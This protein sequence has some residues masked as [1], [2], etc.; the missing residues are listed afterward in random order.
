MVVGLKVW[1]SDT[2]TFV[3]VITSLSP[4]PGSWPPPKVC[5]AAYNCELL[6][7]NRPKIESLGLVSS[8]RMLVWSRVLRSALLAAKLFAA[9]G[10]VGNG[11]CD[12]MKPAD[13]V[14]INCWGM[15]LFAKGCRDTPK[16][17]LGQG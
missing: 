3:V 12:C 16:V 6:K 11:N 14:L 8:I 4:K 1:V 15:V 5:L 13:T 10:P 7:L 2:A 9:P 17:Q